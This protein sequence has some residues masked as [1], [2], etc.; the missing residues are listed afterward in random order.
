[1]KL[2]ETTFNK[3]QDKDECLFLND[4]KEIVHCQ[5]VDKGMML[6]IYRVGYCSLAQ[7]GTEH[8]VFKIEHD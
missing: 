2:T 4:R 7:T 3:L 6:P 1:M 5:K 8:K